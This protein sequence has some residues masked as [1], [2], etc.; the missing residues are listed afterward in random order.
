MY[1][2]WIFSISFCPFHNAFW[3][4]YINTAVNS[5]QILCVKE[6]FSTHNLPILARSG[7]VRH[8]KC[9][10]IS[11]RHLNQLIHFVKD[12]IQSLTIGSITLSETDT[13]QLFDILHQ[14]S[15]LD[16]ISITNCILPPYT[17][18]FFAAFVEEK[19]IQNIT[20]RSLALED[21]SLHSIISAVSS[22][23]VLQTL[24]LSNIRLLGEFHI[25]HLVEYLLAG[26]LHINSLFLLDFDIKGS[27]IDELEVLKSRQIARRIV[28][29]T[30]SLYCVI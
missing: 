14:C 1:S 12:D 25:T 26:N 11:A 3:A 15:N 29:S 27:L 20:L 4:P 28:Y 2:I 24:S 30:N 23:S 18:S 9:S 13:S 16:D 21:C 10:N 22:L 8:L 6:P 17:W 7:G 19:E 5:S